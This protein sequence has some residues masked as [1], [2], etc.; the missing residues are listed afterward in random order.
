VFLINVPAMLAVLVFV[1]RF[2]PEFSNPAAPRV[3]VPSAA[4]LMLAVLPATYGVKQIARGDGGTLPLALV[5]AGLAVGALFMARQGRI[6]NPL[7]NRG[8]FRNRVFSVALGANTTTTFV[9]FGTFF[10]VS[11]YFQLVL[12]LSP[13]ASALWSL[14]GIVAM[15]VGTMIVVPRL[16]QSHRPGPLM[17]GGAAIVAVGLG[18][19]GLMGTDTPPAVVAAVLAVFQFGV[20]PLIILGNNLI[21]G[22]APPEASGAAAGTSQTFNELGGALGIALLGS[23]GTAVYRGQVDTG[24]LSGPD[25]SAVHDTLA[26]ATSVAG[27]IP[28]T[29]LAG[30]QHAFTSGMSVVTVLAAA[31][32][33]AVAGAIARFL[34][35]IAA[36]EAE[37]PEEPA[38]ALAAA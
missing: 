25:A 30:A 6:T 21:I 20:A 14:P 31:L 10:F 24:G 12:G 3:D 7:L 5:A 9:M 29:A 18:L 1:P 17:A 32:M 23:L 35:A 15:S 34:G 38:A 37:A 27:R 16:A 26:G 33:L 11:Q 19:F 2:V 8:L 13:L 22:S 28:D 4:L 36:P